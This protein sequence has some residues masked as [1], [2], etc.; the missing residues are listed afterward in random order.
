MSTTAGKTKEL[1]LITDP[2]FPHRWL[3]CWEGGGELSP[4]LGGSWGRDAGT[5]KIQAFMA[6][7]E[8]DKVEKKQNV[9]SSSK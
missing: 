1:K 3:I 9:K 8:A 5:K 4:E 6:K 7:K 2:D